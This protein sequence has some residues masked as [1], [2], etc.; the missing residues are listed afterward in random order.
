[1]SSQPVRRGRPVTAPNSLPFLRRDSPTSSLSSVGNGPPPT[2]VQY[3]LVTPATMLIEF[4]GTP[5]PVAA[6][7]DVA[8]DEV[9]NG[10]V[11][12]SMSNIVPWA[13]SKRTDLPS[14][15][16]RFVNSAVSQIYDLIFSPSFRVSSTSCEK[17]I[18]AP[19]APR[20]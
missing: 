2:R 17:S 10:Y 7:P 18:C 9:T 15:S 12:W 3:A 11:P 6:P 14:S 13:P 8:L 20:A 19:Y 4:G 5:V 16:A 1:M